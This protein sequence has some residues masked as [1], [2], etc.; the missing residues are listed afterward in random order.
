MWHCKVKSKYMPLLLS[1]HCF[2]ILWT[3][4]LKMAVNATFNEQYAATLFP[5]QPITPEKL[6]SRIM[7]LQQWGL[8]FTNPPCNGN[9]HPPRAPRRST[10]C[11]EVDKAK[12]VR[13]R[14]SIRMQRE[15]LSKNT[16]ITNRYLLRRFLARSRQDDVRH[17]LV[18]T[19][20]DR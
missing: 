5:Q 2:Y 3:E 13:W 12:H 7:L 16:R 20:P 14:I 11:N 10:G 4:R 15:S 9:I 19:T 17:L 8:L 1:C 6:K 18:D